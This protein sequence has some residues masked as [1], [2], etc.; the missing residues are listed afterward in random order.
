MFSFKKKVINKLYAI[1]N[2]L[3]SHLYLIPSSWEN[4][5]ET[6]LPYLWWSHNKSNRIFCSRERSR[7]EWYKLPAKA[8]LFQGGLLRTSFSARWLC[9]WQL[10]KIFFQKYLKLAQ[11]VIFGN[12]NKWPKL[13]TFCVPAAQTITKEAHCLFVFLN[14]LK[15][16]TSNFQPA[17]MQS[18]PNQQLLIYST[19]KGS[20]TLY[21]WDCKRH[22]NEEMK[23]LS[24]EWP[25]QEQAANI[26][27]F[28]MLACQGRRGSF[29][30]S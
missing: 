2:T 10:A 19:K 28:Q 18:L 23:L 13:H 9:C 11:K 8:E 14:I 1:Y 30:S 27:C 21:S 29:K 3:F 20:K 24:P 22:K 6:L 16:L 25:I 5:E 7:G 4:L 17:V 26:P 15:I 12:A